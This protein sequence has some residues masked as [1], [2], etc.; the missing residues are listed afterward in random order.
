MNY[1]RYYNVLIARAKKRVLVGY[2]ERHHVIPV[3]V[4]GSDA[5]ENIVRLTP[6]EHYVAHQMLVKMYPTEKGLLWATMVMTGGAGHQPRK[7]KLYGWLR[8]R[9]AAEMTGKPKSVETRA[10]LAAANKGQKHTPERCANISLAKTGRRVAPW[11]DQR[12]ART[13]A[14]LTGKRHSEQAK[15]KMRAAKLGK[16][17]SPEAC[18]KLSATRFGRVC[19]PETRAKIAAAQ[20]GRKGKIPSSETRAKMSES[21]KKAWV[22]RRE[23]A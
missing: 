6:E 18:A 13:V 20:A 11:S 19:S 12:R 10:K 4:G 17:L 23:A 14:A 15:A 21:A 9:V 3:C 8:R 16:P 7:N 1:A 2:S 5:P 22:T